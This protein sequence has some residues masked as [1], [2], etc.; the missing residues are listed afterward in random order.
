M[1]SFRPEYVIEYE[2][3][4][5]GRS[6]TKEEAA[7]GIAPPPSRNCPWHRQ[8]Q[9][10][11][12]RGFIAPSGGTELYAYARGQAARDLEMMATAAPDKFH[13]AQGSNK[14]IGITFDVEHVASVETI[15]RPKRR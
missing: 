11:R 6:Q 9:C 4:S 3:P 5:I 13:I 12:G 15:L 8:I 14:E 7:R 1:V 10:R 2:D